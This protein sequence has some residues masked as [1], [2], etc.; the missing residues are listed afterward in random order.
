[1]ASLAQVTYGCQVGAILRL[2]KKRVHGGVW[3]FGFR[4]KRAAPFRV[5]VDFALSK[6]PVQVVM[7][8]P[9]LPTFLRSP[10]EFVESGLKKI[11]NHRGHGGHGVN[12]GGDWHLESEFG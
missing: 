11:F 4:N 10:R 3:L 6:I 9:S 1:M 5:P 2:K 12:L 7:L 8:L